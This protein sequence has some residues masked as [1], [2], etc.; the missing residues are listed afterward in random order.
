VTSFFF[1]FYDF[2]LVVFLEGVAEG[3]AKGVAKGV[4]FG[5]QDLLMLW[6]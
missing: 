3:V 6:L 2:L 1:D 5:V 4:V